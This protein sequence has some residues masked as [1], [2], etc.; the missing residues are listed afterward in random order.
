M[1]RYKGLIEDIK[2]YKPKA[3]VEVG[4]FN[5]GN[6][7]RMLKEAVKYRDNVEYYGFDLFEDI[8]LEIAKQENTALKIPPSMQEVYDKLEGYT[9]E[10]NKGYTVNTLPYFVE[11]G[12]V[13]DFVFI[14]GGHSYETVAND[15]RWIEK[16]MGD[17]TVVYFDDYLSV[18]EKAGWGCHKVID[19]LEGYEVKKCVPFDVFFRDG[20]LMRDWVVK[21]TRRN[22]G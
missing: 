10:L 15:W 1:G 17:D 9:V 18:K 2:L 12:I 21:V 3:I 6:A 11:R 5:G 7:L 16:I 8:M 14:D 4:T 22:D 13:P 19:N 20:M